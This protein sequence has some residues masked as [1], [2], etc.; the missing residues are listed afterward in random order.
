MSRRRRIPS[1]L[2]CLIVGY[3]LLITFG[4]GADKL[5][6]IP[7]TDQPDSHG[8]SRKTTPLNSGALETCIARSTARDGREPE[9]FL[10]EFCGNGTRAEDIAS[11][12]AHRWDKHPIEVWAVNYPG[13][14]GSTGLAKLDLL[15][16]AGLSA[17][18]A[19]CTVA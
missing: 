9:A 2:A 6:L 17:Y 8:A 16:P 18:D 11:Y 1:I 13:F 15:A 5:L 4:G 19:L 3:L 14:G 10:L 7:S 12:V